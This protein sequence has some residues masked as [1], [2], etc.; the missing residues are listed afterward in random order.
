MNDDYGSAVL[1]DAQQAQPAQQSRP[2]QSGATPRHFATVLILTIVIIATLI[3]VLYSSGIM[4][5]RAT[6]STP[7]TTAQVYINLHKTV[8]NSTF[9]LFGLLNSSI[10][11]QYI[12]G[13][14]TP[15]VLTP[16]ITVPE[17][18]FNS[19]GLNFTS[20]LMTAPVEYPPWY[21]LNIPA[22]YSNFTY[23][24]ITSI[25]AYNTTN[26]SA[27]AT[28]YDY[29]ISGQRVFGADMNGTAVY[30]KTVYYAYNFSTVVNKGVPNYTHTGIISRYPINL[31]MPGVNATVL[32][33]Y[34]MY[35]TTDDYV[36]V[37]KYSHYMII[38]EF[39]GV[40]GKF[41]QKYGTDIVTNYYGK[42]YK[43]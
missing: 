3:V 21:T 19:Y 10:Y 26:D 39:Y 28:L 13:T 33:S 6:T 42:A 34:P 43:V 1:P 17:A 27:A 31:G 40:I 36:I 7:S 29:E 20:D 25:Y 8:F 11:H 38:F 14:Y 12:N 4:H 5:T 9:L 37:T 35:N 2:I 22:A 30:N 32:D 16:N 41:N 18:V 23:P 24:I 15:F